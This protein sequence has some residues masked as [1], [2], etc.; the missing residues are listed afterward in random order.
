MPAVSANNPCTPIYELSH[1]NKCIIYRDKLCL[2]NARIAGHIERDLE[3][4]DNIFEWPH[5]TSHPEEC[6]CDAPCSVRGSATS[7]LG[8]VVS[9]VW[10]VGACYLWFC[11]Q[12][13]GAVL[14]VSWKH[15]HRYVLRAKKC[16][17][18]CAL[19]ENS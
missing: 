11:F 7:C 4:Q 15:S 12:S 16:G 19:H 5:L 13:L 1:T 2:H 9:S 18:F 8:A 3:L 17:R 6:H 10:R 14:S